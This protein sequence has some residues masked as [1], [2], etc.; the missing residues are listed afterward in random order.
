MGENIENALKKLEKETTSE[1]ERLRILSVF[2]DPDKEFIV[3]KSLYGS[4]SEFVE[5][6][7]NDGRMGDFNKIWRK[8]ELRQQVKSVGFKKQYIYWAAAILVIGMLLGNLIDIKNPKIQ[9]LNWYTAK[10]PRG[11]VAETILPD[12]TIIYLNAGSEIKYPSIGNSTIREVYL[13]GEA[14]FDVTK[15]T[16]RPF[17]VHTDFY[18]VKV[19]GTE[20]NVKSYPDDH[21]IITTLEEGSVQ[22]ESTRNFKIEKSI[23]LEPGEQLVYHKQNKSLH[24]NRVKPEIYSSWKD[25]SLIFINMNLG[26]LITL[27]ERKYG[28]DIVVADESILNYHY[29]GTIK[30]ETI[31]EVLTILQKTLPIDYV[32]EDQVVRILKK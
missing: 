32:I 23:K 28:V 15:S 20:F 26:E 13:T 19:T 21:E 17:I 6:E 30:N 9:D 8:I 24:L 22:I 29:D 2:N 16:D 1:R 11:S 7:L 12:G 5:G 3:K 27:L 18:D 25:N 31:I 14:W 10:A 4:L